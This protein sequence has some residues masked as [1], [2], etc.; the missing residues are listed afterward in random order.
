M[1]ISKDKNIVDILTFLQNKLGKEN[2]VIID[3]WNADRTAI[4]ISNKTNT[5]LIYVSTN[6]KKSNEYFIELEITN[7]KNKEEYIKCGA[8]DGIDSDQVLSYVIKHFEINIKTLT[9]KEVDK[10]TRVINY[11]IDL[12]IIYSMT[13]LIQQIFQTQ[14]NPNIIAGIL[15][16][17]YYLLLESIFGQTLGKKI[18]GT[19][20]LDLDNKKPTFLKFFFTDCFEI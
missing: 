4:G 1:V 15:F 9:K 11:I 12:F 16:F 19:C 14:L 6:K 20:V 18:T 10:G 13:I 17:F 3:H 7:Q 8:F 5:K 2:I